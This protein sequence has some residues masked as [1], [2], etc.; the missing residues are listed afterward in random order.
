MPSIA[1]VLLGCLTLGGE[2]SASPPTRL[3]VRTA[4]S[5]AKVTLEG[6]L[7]GKSDA[8]FTVVPG[9]QTVS[10]ELDGYLPEERRVEI[11]AEEVTR[12]ELQ[13]KRR[14]VTAGQTSTPTL[15][16]A[17]KAD[18]EKKDDAASKAANA[19]V[20][21]ANLS[22]PVREAMLT[23]LRQHPTETRWSG[24]A[25]TI[26]FGIAARRLP[27]GS[28]R[29]QAIPSMLNLTGMLAFQELLKAKCLL[30]RYA[31]VGLTDANTL[32]RA[33]MESA[34][35]LRVEGK[36]SAI[37]QGAAVQGDYAVGY[38]T[39]EERALLARLLQETELEKVRSAYRDVMHRQARQLMDRSNWKDALLLWHHLHARKLVS[40][41]LYLDA[42]RCFKELSQNEDAVRVLDE[43]I[44]TFHDT[45]TTE[46]LEQAADMALA[47]PT[48]PAQEL[49]K[50]TYDT[51]SD[52]LKQTVS[53]PASKASAEKKS[54]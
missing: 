29:Q 7:L 13:L 53:Q 4:P 14:P 31:A 51:V 30:D 52:R 6:K 34:G 9:T 3:Y 48:D 1:L 45:A 41:Q 2:P 54:Q 5:G 40:Q 50:K 38:V 19:Y 8:I 43:A 22:V 35:T 11:R 12:V 33:V 18:A 17:G 42:A 16:S 39:A 36:A 49:A 27:R 28:I 21:D 24:R 26:M 32:Q 10:V 25:G 46:F 23:V 15:P 47:I 44:K 20:A 37:L